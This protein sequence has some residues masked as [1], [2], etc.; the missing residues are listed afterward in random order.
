M[1]SIGILVD[2]I[3]NEIIYFILR[4]KNQSSF[5]LIHWNHINIVIIFL[6]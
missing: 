5:S 3:K 2:F 6:I 1:K 4:L